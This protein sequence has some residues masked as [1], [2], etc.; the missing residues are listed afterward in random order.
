MRDFKT[1][2]MALLLVVA[3]A[4]LLAALTGCDG[5]RLNGWPASAEFS[6]L[7]N[8]AARWSVHESG[9]DGLR[10]LV[11]HETGV[12]YAVMGGAVYPL[13]DSDGAPLRVR[14]AG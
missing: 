1:L 14:E 3:G 6:T 2:F 9:M 11:D 8:G 10:V 7:T 5:E 4:W 13:V 12:E